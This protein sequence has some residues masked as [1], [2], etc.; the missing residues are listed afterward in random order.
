ML[1]YEHVA[2]SKIQLAYAEFVRRRN[3]AARIVQQCFRARLFRD[4]LRGTIE[5]KRMVIRDDNAPLDSVPQ[6]P[7]SI[8]LPIAPLRDGSQA[9]SPE[10]QT[11]I[12]KLSTR[13]IAEHFNIPRELITIGPVERYVG[14]VKFTAT[15][16][17]RLRHDLPRLTD[18]V[19]KTASIWQPLYDALVEKHHW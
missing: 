11:I 8:S 18:Q 2:A 16:P 17:Q 9:V 15:I 19:H 4:I 10:A 6:A 12:Q 14:G 13:F 3:D 7:T 5:A 1:Q